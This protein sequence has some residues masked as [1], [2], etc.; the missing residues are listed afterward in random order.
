MHFGAEIKELAESDND[1]IKYRLT[2]IFTNI[3]NEGK[4]TSN[5]YQCDS[6][7]KI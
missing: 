6:W 3:A 7:L 5:K 1:T 2:S 4:T